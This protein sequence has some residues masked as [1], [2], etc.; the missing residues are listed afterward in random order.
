MAWTYEQKF[1]TLSDGD[2]QGQDSWTG[3]AGKWTVTTDGSPT[4]G[5]KCVKLSADADAYYYAYRNVDTVT[6]GT[7]Y[8]SWKMTFNATTAGEFVLRDSSGNNS[9]RISFEPDGNI[10]AYNSSGPAWDVIGTFSANTWVRIGIAF[11]YGAGSWEGLSADSFKVSVNN[12]AW[13]SAK[14]MQTSGTNCG[15]IKLQGITKTTAGNTI[16]VDFISPDYAAVSTPTVTTQAATSI[17]IT[18]ATSNGNITN[19]GG[20]NCDKRGFVYGSGSHDN[21]GNVAPASSGYGSSTESSGS[22]GTGAFSSAISGLSNGTVYYYRPFAHNSAGY[23]YGDEVN[24]TTIFLKSATDSGTGNETIS[25]NK[26]LAI[27]DSGAGVDNAAIKAIIGILDSG[28]GSEQLNSSI[29]V[30]ISDLGAGVDN[31]DVKQT[32]VFIQDSCLGNDLVSLINSYISVS[33]NGAGIDALTLNQFKTVLDNGYG[34]EG[35]SLLTKIALP[36]TGQGIDEVCAIEAKIAVTDSGSGGDTVLKKQIYIIIDTGLGADEI[37]DLL[38]QVRIL[39]TGQGIDLIHIP[40]YYK[41][42]FTAR[43]TTYTNKFSSR[44]TIWRN[45]FTGF[46]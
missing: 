42:K 24:F 10:Y 32:G 26:Q 5:A 4:E 44:G 36:D 6:N 21:P 39:D 12:G 28:E 34:V 37:T 19:T 23:T 41:D 25:I 8:F 9:C 46:H 1:N 22:Y 30:L 14:S 18:T 3:D 33:D 16:Y 17:G 15:S 43:G 7:V 13:S 27:T 31:E 2:L 45:K 35:I 38:R 29:N 20:E 11:E 40:T